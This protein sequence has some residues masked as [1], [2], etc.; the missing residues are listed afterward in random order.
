MIKFFEMKYFVSMINERMNECYMLM[1][2]LYMY[3]YVHDFVSYY[4]NI[5]F[6]IKF[7]EMK[8]FVDLQMNK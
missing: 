8:Y 3:L 6:M 1:N 2:N 7:I 5:F 4:V